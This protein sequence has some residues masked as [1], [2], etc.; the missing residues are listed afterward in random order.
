MRG[1]ILTILGLIVIAS[2][3]AGAFI[4]NKSEA[5]DSIVSNPTQ[6]QDQAEDTMSSNDR[7]AAGG[8]TYTDY[9]EQ[10]LDNAEGQAVLFFHA[11][12]CPQCRAI[13]DDIQQLG[14]PAGYTILKV[15]YDTRQDLRQKY[16]VRLQTTFVK[17]AP[18]GD[19]ISDF[20]AYNEP[21]LAALSRDYLQ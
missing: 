2:L 5:P 13:E 20:V 1:R 12:W 21:T 11:P 16:G 19:K 8:G 15:D 9:S 4:F 10:A 14:V 6:T 7:P 17:V 18:N 3:M